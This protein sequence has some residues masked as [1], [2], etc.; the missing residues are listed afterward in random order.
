MYYTC[1]I[2][3]NSAHKSDLLLLLSLPTDF[4]FL[5]KI[6]LVATALL[7]RLVWLWKFSTVSLC[8]HWK[9]HL[10]LELLW[11]WNLICVH[12]SVSILFLFPLAIML[13]CVGFFLVYLYLS[14]IGGNLIVDHEKVW[15]WTGMLPYFAFSNM[16][17]LSTA[18]KIVI[19]F[20]ILTTLETSNS[21]CV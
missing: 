13:T 4:R 14:V 1:T 17:P 7:G 11:V 9:G 10:S 18:I 6:N 21:K 12:V 2:H 20:T 16:K 5:M 15:W 19:V 8:S 3:R